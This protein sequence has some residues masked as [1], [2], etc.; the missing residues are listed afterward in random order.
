MSI[1]PEMPMMIMVLKIVP[2]QGVFLFSMHQMFGV[3]MMIII[4]IGLGK[5]K[6]SG[7]VKDVYGTTSTNF[8]T[9]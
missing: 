1:H 3:F 8:N 6:Y 2:P 7:G 9:K 5:M 4:C